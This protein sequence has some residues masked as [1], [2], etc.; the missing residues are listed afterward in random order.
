MSVRSRSQVSTPGARC[1][2]SRWKR[3]CGWWTMTVRSTRAKKAT[4]TSSIASSKTDCE[5]ESKPFVWNVIP[6]WNGTMAVTFNELREG[7]D[8]VRHLIRLLPDLRAVVLV[9]R[10]A[11]RAKPLLEGIGLDLRE[12]AHPSPRVRASRPELWRAIPKVWA[13][14]AGHAR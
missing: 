13:E 5:L 9:G 10:K 7:V 6:W 4:S 3:A 12:S 1:A 2:P 14:I 11:A 8:L